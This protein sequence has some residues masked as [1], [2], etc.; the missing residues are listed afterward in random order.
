MAQHDFDALRERY[1]EAIREMAPVFGSHEFIRMLTSRNQKLYVEALYTYRD[2]APFQAVHQQ[3]AALL[4]D[5]P[6]LVARD[7]EITD[8]FDIW[9]QPNGCSRWRRRSV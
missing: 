5:F 1:P 8:S 4:N 2:G 3:L 6:D 7:G 9:T